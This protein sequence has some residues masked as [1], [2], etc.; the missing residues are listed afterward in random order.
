MTHTD[1]SIRRIFLVRHGHYDRV[2]DLGDAVW[3]LSPLGRR[4]AARTGRFL[5]RILENSTIP[6]EGLYASPWPRGTQTAEVA[7]REMDLKSVKVKPYL[8]ES[9]PLVDLNYRQTQL[10]PDDLAPTDTATRDAV[11]RQVNRVRARFFAP[12]RQQ[13]SVVMIVTHGNLIRYLVARTLGIPY[14]AWTSLD[15]THCG[16]TEMRVYASGFEAIVSFNSAEHLP[17]SMHTSS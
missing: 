5:A 9:V 16:V 14:E 6:F 4:Q 7:A 2:G 15:T 12:P 8:H 13:S 17:I 10:F 11:H 3:G 1:T